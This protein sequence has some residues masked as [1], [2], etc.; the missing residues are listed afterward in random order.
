MC[1][2]PQALLSVSVVFLLAGCSTNLQLTPRVHPAYIDDLR[3]EYLRTKPQSPYRTEV[4]KGEVVKG[5]DPVAVLAAW[6]HPERR[7]RTGPNEKWTYLDKDDNSG[8]EMQYTLMFRQGVL[9]DWEIMR[10][11]AGITAIRSTMPDAPQ[12]PEESRRG[13][14]VPPR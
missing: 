9:N 8:D 6:G 14:S 12:P 2:A 3:A 4:T 13:K 1:R 10:H 7:V 11:I 5:M